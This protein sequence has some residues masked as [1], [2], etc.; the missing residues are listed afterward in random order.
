MQNQNEHDAKIEQIW[1]TYLTKGTADIELRQRR[2]FRALPG[3]SRCRICWAPFRGAASPLVRVIFGKRPS[4][5]NPQMCNACEEFA[6]RHQGGVELELSLLFADVR[7]STTLAEHMAPSDFG[8][9]INRFYSTATE[10]MIRHNALI[11]KIIGDQVAGMFV[12]GFA[13][14]DHGHK[15][16]LAAKELLRDTD[17]GK[18][19]GPWIPLGVGIHTGPTYFGTVASEAGNFDVT[20]LGDAP[21]TAARLSSRA[22]VG[23]ILISEN[24]WLTT[25]M[26]E[27]GLEKR[28]LFLKGKQQPVTVYV[29]TDYE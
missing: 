10:V 29:L 23:E 6:R 4:N 20:V 26:G 18:E 8:R 24:T 21:N 5:M 11:D 14:E 12:P 19:G 2:I 13:G 28:E 17:H 27:E 22:A 3:S 25:G 9:L 16:I 15:T 1:R 7:G